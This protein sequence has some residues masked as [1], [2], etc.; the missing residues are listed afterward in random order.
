MNKIDTVDFYKTL[1][2][3]EFDFFT[4]VPDSLLKELCLCIEDLAAEKHILAANEGNAVAIACGYHITTGRFGVV[5]MQNSGIGNAVNP[6][7]SLADEKVYQIPMLLLIGYRGEPGVKDEPQHQK[8]GELTL[9]L[10]ETLGIPWQIVDDNYQQQIKDCHDYMKQNGKTMALVIKKDTFAKY[11]S[12]GV[13]KKG[14]RDNTAN[15]LAREQALHAILTQLDEDEFVV[16]TT[17]K[18]SREIFEIREAQ[19]VGHANDFLTVGSM[20]HASSLALGISQNTDK[21]IYCIDGDGAFLM[22]MGGLAIAV[23]NVKDN[24]KYILINNG[25][26]ESVGG[27]PTIANQLELDKILYGMGFDKVFMVKAEEELILALQY[28][29]KHGK[30]AIVVW[31]NQ[32]SRE[33]LGRPTTTPIE[34]KENFEMKIRG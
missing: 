15:L 30:C 18:T 1:C 25:C 8:Q 14:K 34:N 12:T 17:G 2:E 29:K 16:S 31:T 5:Y 7:L 32:T 19:H 10:L 22:H 13:E 33:N 27:Q 11:H 6:L 21:N 28:Q 26:H 20:G 24:F 9:P 3:N 4:G 23:Q